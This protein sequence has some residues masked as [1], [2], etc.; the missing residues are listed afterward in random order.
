MTET[1]LSVRVDK[2]L[3]AARLF[4]TRSLATQACDAGHVKINGSSVKPS[5]PVRA[6]DTLEVVT[7]GGLRIVEVRALLEKRVSAPLARELYV[8]HSPPPTEAE[9]YSPSG[10]RA[11]GMGRPTKRDR[12]LLMRLKG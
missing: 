7:L 9:V 4:K 10:R 3:W 12:R 8:D 2:W 6:S 5:R 11:R 1:P